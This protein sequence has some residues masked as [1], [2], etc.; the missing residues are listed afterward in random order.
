[1]GKSKGKGKKGHKGGKNGHRSHVA[2][3]ALAFES[4]KGK[5]KVKPP[6][7]GTFKG[8]GKFS[9]FGNRGKGKTTSAVV[10]DF[11]ATS[12]TPSHTSITCGFCHKIGHILKTVESD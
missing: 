7:K 5:G 10:S 1:L 3:P 12:G 2:R 11:N 4:P 6:F 9:S 8:K